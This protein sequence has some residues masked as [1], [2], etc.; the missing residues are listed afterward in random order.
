M[1]QRKVKDQILEV[2][3]SALCEYVTAF[4]R[5][6]MAQNVSFLDSE[7]HARDVKNSWP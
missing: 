5:I 1:R 6:Q 3:N 4:C 7:R 2:R